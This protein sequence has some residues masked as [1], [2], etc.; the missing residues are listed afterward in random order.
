VHDAGIAVITLDTFVGDGNYQSGKETW[1]ASYIGTPNLEAGKLAGE[2]IVEMLE[3]YGKVYVQ[4]AA[5]GT[6]S[7]VQRKQGLEQA[8]AGTNVTIVGEQFDDGNVAK[9]TSQTS[10]ALLASD[11]NAVVGLDLF[12]AEG[13]T[14]AVVNANKK[15]LVKVICFD[16]T[17]GA[18]LA[19]RRGETQLVVGQQ[20]ALIGTLGVQT[21]GRV[22][23]G[24]HVEK[25][26]L[27]KCVLITP[28]TVDTPEA[29]SAVYHVK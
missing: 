3:G 29:Q 1:P 10:A 25:Q 27:V 12:S 19:L 2:A 28:K 14:N 11:V 21:A 24:E 23:A 4:N 26:Q 8:F 22:L 7:L 20:P 18:I 9:A 16:S 6:S 17:E 5:P 13:A 15:G